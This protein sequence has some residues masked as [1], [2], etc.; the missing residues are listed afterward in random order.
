MDSQELLEKNK[1]EIKIVLI[2]EEQV[3]KTSI[4]NRFIGKNFEENY[5][6]TNGT[7]YNEKIIYVENK[8]ITLH[9]WDCSGQEKFRTLSKHFFTNTN[10]FI[11]VY[12]ITN[13]ESLDKLKNWV[14][15]ARDKVGEFKSII[16]GNKSDLC[17]DEETVKEE[18]KKLAD[19]MGINFCLVSAKNNINIE[20]GFESIIKEQMALSK[21]D[22]PETTDSFNLRIF[23]ENKNYKNCCGYS[24]MLSRFKIEPKSRKLSNCERCLTCCGYYSC[25][26]CLKAGC[27]GCSE[28]CCG[29]EKCS[30]ETCKRCCDYIA[31]GLC[32]C[33]CG[34]KLF[35][36]EKKVCCCCHCPKEGSVF[37]YGE[38]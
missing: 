9:L 33:C 2:G 36:G 22:I 16:F 6:P 7:T 38:K 29:K 8:K 24:K 15:E 19:E 12:D 37:I 4:L 32:Y 11:F 31:C 13:K 27:V 1:N 21:T 20:E 34:S 28:C 18:G 17:T 3:G 5:N 26:I 30:K 10:V 23:K 25:K 35:D 14:N